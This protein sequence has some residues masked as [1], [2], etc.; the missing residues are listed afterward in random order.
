MESQRHMR[1]L[2]GSAPRRHGARPQGVVLAALSVLCVTVGAC[3][4]NDADQVTQPVVLGMTPS[5]A[6]AYDDG[7]TQMYQVQVPVRLPIRKP[8]DAELR[9]L[10]DQDPYPRM[11]YLKAS[12]VR[13]EVHWTITNL[14]DADHDV[15]L[16]V[17]PW[18]EF[19]RYKPGIVV[20][21]EMT[22]PNPSG[23]DVQFRVHAKERR[24]GTLTT[25]DMNELA[26]DLATAENL[27][28][29]PPQDPNADVAGIMNRAF[30]VHNRSNQSDPIVGPYIPKVIAGLTGFDLGLRMFEKG[31]VAIEISMDLTDLNGQRVL[32]DTFDPLKPGD[33]VIHMPDGVISPPGARILN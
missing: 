26:I 31:T 22:E 3:A 11:P 25:D 21:D 15:Q 32:T 8:T 9:G 30:D 24:T 23:W 17:D 5:V 27:T 18:N 29:N 2:E 7:E 10:P 6:A 1:A 16:L 20:S 12:D 19:V 14:D 4:N 33:K 28:K 13:I